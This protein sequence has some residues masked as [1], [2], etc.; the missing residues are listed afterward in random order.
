[1]SDIDTVVVDSLKAL[2]PEWPIREADMGAWFGIRRMTGYGNRLIQTAVVVRSSHT[3]YSERK[4]PLYWLPRHRDA[5]SRAAQL[6]LDPG[7]RARSL[8]IF[9]LS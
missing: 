7:I 3:L 8:Q 2:D 1:V 9:R 5:V 4:V 6:S